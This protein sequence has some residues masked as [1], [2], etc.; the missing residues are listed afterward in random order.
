MNIINQQAVPYKNIRTDKE[1]YFNQFFEWDKNGF[2]QN[3]IEDDYIIQ[4]VECPN[5]EHKKKIQYYKKT[6]DKFVEVEEKDILNYKKANSFKNLK[7]NKN[8]GHP[9]GL[10]YELN[11]Y[12]N[13]INYSNHH[14]STIS[15]NRFTRD[16]SHDI[17]SVV[18]KGIHW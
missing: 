15:G 1:E 18:T 9:K 8:V 5:F 13:V 14:T 12:S 6:D 2:H 7:T 3:N 16:S 4:L 11:L 10:F 17:N